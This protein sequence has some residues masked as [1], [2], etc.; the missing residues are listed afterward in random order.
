MLLVYASLNYYVMAMILISH[1]TNI[2]YLASNHPST[3]FEQNYIKLNF[4]IKYLQENEYVQNYFFR[5]RNK[6]VV[7]F[8]IICESR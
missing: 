1:I 7:Q 2:I 8:A 3:K 6:T 4:N 5:Y